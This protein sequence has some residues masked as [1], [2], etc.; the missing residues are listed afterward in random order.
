[1]GKYGNPTKTRRHNG[2]I[3]VL[4]SNLQPINQSSVSSF[5]ANPLNMTARSNQIQDSGSDCCMI[6]TAI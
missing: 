2:N 1:M 6:N 5:L 3:S 4:P